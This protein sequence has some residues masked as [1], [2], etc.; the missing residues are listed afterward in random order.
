MKKQKNQYVLVKRPDGKMMY[1]HDGKYFDPA[2]I[3]KKPEA[4][5][6]PD[7][8]SDIFEME[9]LKED[10]ASKQKRQN[11]D[12]II[13]QHSEQILKE[14]KISF[15]SKDAEEKFL[16]YLETFLREIRKEKEFLYIL[17]A[18]KTTGGL[19]LEEEQAQKILQVSNRHLQT[20]SDKVRKHHGVPVETCLRRVS[21][22]PAMPRKKIVVKE[23]LKFEKPKLSPKPVVIKQTPNQSS[24]RDSGSGRRKVEDVKYNPI[25]VG[26]LEELGRLDLVAFRR[27]GKTNDARLSELKEMF[28]LLEEESVENKMQAKQNWT[29]SPLYREY[30]ET[31]FQAL[32][33]A[34]PVKDFLAKQGETALK[35]DEFLTIIKL[36]EWLNY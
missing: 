5:K 16:K 35:V 17:T 7:V 22:K 30:L 19:G 2:E 9:E 21:E 15:S 4:E 11:Q 31:G 27:L 13:Q 6:K 28:D 23:D 1:Y 20:F 34:R 12:A 33:Q 8:D 26:P 36:N 24:L 29:R 25:L 18:A 3:Q 32:K 14:L 10:D